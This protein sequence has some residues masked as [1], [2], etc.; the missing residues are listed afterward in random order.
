VF[1]QIFSTKEL[2]TELYYTIAGTWIELKE[3]PMP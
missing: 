3:D 2:F 1:G